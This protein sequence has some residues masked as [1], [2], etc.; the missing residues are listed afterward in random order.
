MS[1]ESPFTAAKY[2]ETQL[3]GILTQI[4]VQSLDKDEQRL[5]L[6][7][8]RDMT[9][10]RLDI[11]DYELSETRDEQLR[12]AR[13][14][15]HRLDLVRKGILAVSEYNVFTAVDVAQLGA[16]IEQISENVR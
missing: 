3:S 2:L 14:A 11:R 16:Q 9:D 10:A 12:K 5:I 8:R 1:T 7:L 6:A 15:K 13:D 4:D